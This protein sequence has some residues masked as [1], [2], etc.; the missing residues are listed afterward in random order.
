MAKGSKKTLK[1]QQPKKPH[2]TKK[3]QPTK[4]PN[5]PQNKNPQN[6]GH[7]QKVKSK[8]LKFSGLKKRCKYFKG[9]CTLLRFLSHKLK[10]HTAGILFLPDYLDNV[11][12]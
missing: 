5:H 2:P 9:I 1:N 6:I 3:Q 12:Q 10:T 4:K 8:L 7:S 11:I